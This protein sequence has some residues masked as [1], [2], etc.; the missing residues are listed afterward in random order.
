[1]GRHFYVKSFFRFAGLRVLASKTSYLPPIIT[2]S[3]R[4]AK[5]KIHCHLKSSN[6][7]KNDL[8]DLCRFSSKKFFFVQVAH[9]KLHKDFIHSF[10]ISRT[11]PAMPGKSGSGRTFRPSALTAVSGRILTPAQVCRRQLLFLPYPQGRV[12]K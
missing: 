7:P 2:Q 10:N 9:G 8:T 6:V 11:C 4:K 5:K 12:P 3:G 1:M